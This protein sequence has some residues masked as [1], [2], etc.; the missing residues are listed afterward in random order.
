MLGAFL[1]FWVNSELTGS[2]SAGRTMMIH[3]VVNYL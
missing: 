1:F 2:V 3:C